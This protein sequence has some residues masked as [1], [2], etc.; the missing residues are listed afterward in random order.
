MGLVLRSVIFSLQI[1][2]LAQKLSGLKVFAQL[3]N[4]LLDPVQYSSTVHES[5]YI[6]SADCVC[7]CVFVPV[8]NLNFNENLSVLQK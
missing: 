7:P 1:L 4:L 3:T 8:Y 5:M 2:F 6:K